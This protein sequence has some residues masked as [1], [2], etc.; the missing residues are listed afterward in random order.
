MS[1]EGHVFDHE[2][3]HSDYHYDHHRQFEDER[4]SEYYDTARYPVFLDHQPDTQTANQMRRGDGAYGDDHRI[5]FNN[6]HVGSQP[7]SQ[8]HE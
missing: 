8:Y 5:Q 6:N 1:E 3:G 7:Q 4:H 2:P